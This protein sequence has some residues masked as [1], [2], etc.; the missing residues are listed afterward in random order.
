MYSISRM[1][2]LVILYD[3]GPQTTRHLIVMKGLILPN[4]QLRYS[5]SR[6][7]QTLPPVFLAPVLATPVSQTSCLHTTSALHQRGKRNSPDRGVSTLRRQAATP[8]YKLSIGHAVLKKGLPKPVKKE[9]RKK[10]DVDEDHGLWQF[11][12]DKKLFTDPEEERKFGENG[13]LVQVAQVDEA[14]D[15]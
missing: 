11:F 12:N 9:E 5:I 15:G 3:I 10:L 8:L 14:D 1:R 7:K 13:L 6:L 4:V 2:S